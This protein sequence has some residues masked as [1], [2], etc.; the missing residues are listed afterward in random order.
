MDTTTPLEYQVIIHQEDGSFWAEIP[1]LPGCFAAGDSIEEL[2]D[3]LKES[4]G[5]YLST[6]S[7]TAVVTNSHF[8]PE[9]DATVKKLVLC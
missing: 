9:D 6:P 5:A 3:S 7:S 8:E 2:E 1:A 4:V